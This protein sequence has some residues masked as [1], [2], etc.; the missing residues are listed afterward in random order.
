MVLLCEL[1]FYRLVVFFYSLVAIMG[2]LCG[3][4]CAGTLRYL[5]DIFSALGNFCR[6]AQA[7][8]YFLA[9]MLKGECAFKQHIDA[10][11]GIFI[12]VGDGLCPV[13]GSSRQALGGC[14][15]HGLWSHKRQN[16]YG[17]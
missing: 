12:I 4:A 6:R 1:K 9:R 14:E 11:F 15:R 3:K 7:Y 16:R 8:L 10:V 17:P 13:A 2:M 5:V